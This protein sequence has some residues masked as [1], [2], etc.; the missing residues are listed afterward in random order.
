M[1][2]A[3]LLFLALIMITSITDRAS[4]QTV[5]IQNY[6]IEKYIHFK[7]NDIPAKMPETQKYEIIV[8]RQGSDPVDG[9]KIFAEA[10]KATYYVIGRDSMIRWENVTTSGIE[11][12]HHDFSEGT[13][14]P[15][16]HNFTYKFMSVP[17]VDEDF[18]KS[19]PPE[20][21]DWAMMLLTDAFMMHEYK[22][23][24]LDSLEF[25][26]PYLPE[27][28]ANNHIEVGSDFNFASEYLLYLWNGF[29]IYN[30]QLCAIVRFESFFNLM[31]NSWTKGRSMYYGE[32]FIS[33]DRKQI[34]YARMVEDVVLQQKESKEEWMDMQRIVVLNKME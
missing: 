29:T 6:D 19:I 16:L 31:S 15:V 20:Q 11:D 23:L 27:N 28:M 22:L 17:F 3:G 26:R 18:Y 13:P 24:L 7:M 30:N 2:K 5:K 33:L 34:E 4:S 9:T 32:M 12:L 25:N 10:A 8:K 21:V 14:L 1:K